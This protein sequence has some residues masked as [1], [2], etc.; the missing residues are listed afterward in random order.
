M[1]IAPVTK[2]LGLASRSAGLMAARVMGAGAGLITQLLL[3][4][5]LS[6][7]DLGLFY[8][9]SSMAIVLG[10]VATLGYPGI[11]NQLIARYQAR[12]DDSS[13]LG[14]IGIARRD[15]V[16]VS[17]IIASLCI[18]AT[19]V[20]AGG[21]PNTVWPAAIAA[22]AIPAFAMMRVSGG[23][24]NGF[25]LFALS[26]LP[27]NF[28]RPALFLSALAG[29]LLLLGP[30]SLLEVTS[31]FTGLVVA[32]A[33]IQWLAL[34]WS[35]RTTGTVGKP[36]RSQVKAWRKS[37]LQLVVPLLISALFADI[38]ILCAG[39]VMAPAEVATFGLCIK[40]A[41]LFGFV[42]QVAHQLVMPCFASFLI[43]RDR[44]S[45]ESTIA[46]TNIVA[47][48]AMAAAVCAIALFGEQVLALF[49]DEFR[50][51]TVVLIL[52]GATQMV[53]AL[54]GPALS[55]LIASG[56]H[57]RGIPVIVG[58]LL[59]FIASCVALAPI[60]GAAGAATAVLISSATSCLGLAV[61]VKNEFGLRCDGIANSG[62]ELLAPFLFDRRAVTGSTS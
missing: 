1:S 13:L 12:G 27:D 33:S 15:A 8:I 30:L 44:A 34:R 62:V 26:F 47:I 31:L 38:A 18:A 57:A 11:A 40:I 61:V 9:F 29:A 10:T 24:A 55:L 16:I 19:A 14:F 52:L 49:G 45:I 32:V 60:F 43:D 53:R 56:R 59:L 5:S 48:A 54:G 36:G 37:G 39:F 20:A 58:S 17:L 51:G 46:K 2:V 28:V 42:V 22:L 41:F 3:A 23:L 21:D 35:G 6:P 7:S 50:S 4:H 25:Q